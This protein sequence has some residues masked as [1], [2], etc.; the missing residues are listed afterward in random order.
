MRER[1]TPGRD[2]QGQSVFFNVPSIAVTSG[3]E[4]DR[5]FLDFNV[6]S[7]AQ[8]HL[9]TQDGQTLRETNRQTHR[10]RQN[11]TKTKKGPYNPN[12]YL[13][14]GNLVIWSTFSFYCTSSLHTACIHI[15]IHVSF[16]TPVTGGK[17]RVHGPYL[18]YM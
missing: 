3:C 11:K 4:T 13:Q 2:R 12:D 10:Q 14:H 9:R 7:N 18:L 17:I 15:N 5:E 8:D 1:Q 6:P 16:Q